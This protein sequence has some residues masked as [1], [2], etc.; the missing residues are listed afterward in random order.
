[1]CRVALYG[2]QSRLRGG[3][4]LSAIAVIYAALSDA[5]LYDVVLGDGVVGSGVASGSVAR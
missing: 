1:M 2:M 5:V 3:N 4:A